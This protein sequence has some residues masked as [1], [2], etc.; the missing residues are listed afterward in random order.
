MTFLLN[1]AG[2][3]LCGATIAIGADAAGAAASADGALA[4]ALW[5]ALPVFVSGV[6]LIVSA[7]MVAHVRS[8]DRTVSAQYALLFAHR[9][10]RGAAL[11][12]PG[13]VRRIG[14]R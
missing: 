6:M 7:Q 13:P 8:I 3:A 1:L 12:V 4:A 10:G 11:Q 5:T 9:R 2:F 14:P